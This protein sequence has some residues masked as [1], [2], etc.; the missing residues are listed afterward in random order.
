MSRDA[1]TLHLE[2]QIR[3]NYLIKINLEVVGGEMKKLFYILVTP[4]WF[5]AIMILYVLIMLSEAYSNNKRPLLP[6]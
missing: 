5:M 4:V 6:E 3:I 2:W 1:S